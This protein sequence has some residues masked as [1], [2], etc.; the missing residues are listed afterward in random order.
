MIIIAL[1]NRPALTA[2]EFHLLIWTA[3]VFI[4]LFHPLNAVKKW[5]HYLQDICDLFF[6]ASN[7]E[8]RDITI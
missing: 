4:N 3:E 2:N 1:Y 8:I 6:W 5:S 7:D